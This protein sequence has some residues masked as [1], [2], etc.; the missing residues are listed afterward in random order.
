VCA[1]TNKASIERRKREREEGKEG[2]KEEEDPKIGWRRNS[3]KPS[4]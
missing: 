1:A 3:S 4:P 2:K